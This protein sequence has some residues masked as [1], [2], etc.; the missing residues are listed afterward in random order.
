[1]FRSCENKGFQIKFGNGF[2]VSCQFGVFSYCSN[3]SFCPEDVH[4]EKKVPIWECD[5]CEVAIINSRNGEFITGEILGRMG[6][7]ISN[8]G[9]VAGWVSADDVAKIIAYVSGLKQ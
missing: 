8:D 5:D 9:M 4:K 6:L 2:V 7:N 1:M 3:H